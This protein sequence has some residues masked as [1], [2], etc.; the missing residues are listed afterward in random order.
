MSD[1]GFNAELTVLSKVKLDD[2]RSSVKIKK[3]LSE[4]FDTFVYLKIFFNFGIEKVF[5]KASLYRNDTIY[6]NY[7]CFTSH[8]NLSRQLSN[9]VTLSKSVRRIFARKFC[10][11]FSVAE[12]WLW[13]PYSNCSVRTPNR[14]PRYSLHST[15]LAQICRLGDRA[16]VRE[17]NKLVCVGRT[18]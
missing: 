3:A 7:S 5:R 15:T 10:E 18:K 13:F 11:I 17:E 6:N 8:Y 2:Y 1:L 9:L 12:S 4:P 16:S 14:H